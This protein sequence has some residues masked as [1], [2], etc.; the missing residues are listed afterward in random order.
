MAPVSLDYDGKKGFQII[1]RCEACGAQRRNRAA[2]ETAQPDELAA[3]M[4][5]QRRQAALA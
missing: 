5:G 4:A 3:F 1:H 2:V